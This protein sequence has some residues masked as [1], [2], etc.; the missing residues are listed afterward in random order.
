MSEHQSGLFDQTPALGRPASA[1]LTLRAESGRGLTPAQQAFNRLVGRIEKLRAKLD[2]ETRRL[3]ATLGHFVREIHPRLRRVAALRAELVRALAP[4]LAGPRLKGQRDHRAL[5]DLLATH[6]DAIAAEEG[7]LEA[8]DLRALY[9]QLHGEDIAEVEARE[10]ATRRD[11]MAEMF[12]DLG[13]EIDPA[14]IDP[15]GDDAEIAAKLAEKLLGA[16]EATST[17]AAPRQ[18]KRQRAKEAR[19]KAA[20]ELRQKTIGSIYKQLAKALHP[21]LELN[22]AERARKVVLMQE[23]V[24]AHRAGDLHALLRM[25]LEWLHREKADAT[26]LTEEKLAVFNQALR[27]QARDLE[28][29]IFQLSRDPRYRALARDPA[30]FFPDLWTD[31]PDELRELDLAVADMERSLAAL[32]RPDGLREVRALLA[33]WRAGG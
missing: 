11:M 14:E 28:N 24:A 7:G 1:E 2:R 31:S 26:R 29:E 9:E 27:E 21:D 3:D 13:L 22:P 12:N 8:D 23:L 5:R 17:R 32:R 4:F 33:V 30:S 18:G 6:L 25:E 15:E 10:L 19:E 16:R 20:E